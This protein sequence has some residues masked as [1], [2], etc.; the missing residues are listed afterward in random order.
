L[1][2]VK[3]SA[4][5]DLLPAHHRKCANRRHQ[6]VIVRL[7]TFGHPCRVKFFRKAVSTVMD[8]LELYYSIIEQLAP[9]ISILINLCSKL[10]QLQ[11]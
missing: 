6:G 1:F 5:R 10:A 11:Q 9:A 4:S 2:V 8:D 3:E 7:G